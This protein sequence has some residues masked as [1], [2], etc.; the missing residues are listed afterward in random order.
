ML[1]RISNSSNQLMF[2]FLSVFRLIASR[3]AVQILESDPNLKS[4]QNPRGQNVWG[5]DNAEVNDLLEQWLRTPDRNRQI[6]IEA[7][8]VYRLTEDLPIL[9]INYRIEVITVGKG[10]TGV[11]IRS[12]SPGNNSAWNV[13]TWDRS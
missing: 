12:E 7:S 10:V 8:V 5:Y 4:P 9:P 3:H 1:R 6:D 13:E 2:R 11:P